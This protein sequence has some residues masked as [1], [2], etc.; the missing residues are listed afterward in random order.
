[1]ARVKSLKLLAEIR[2]T[3]HQG[4]A[5]YEPGCYMVYQVGPKNRSDEFL[6]FLSDSWDA[7]SGEI[8]YLLDLDGV[9]MIG[10]SASSAITQGV[11]Q[12][13]QQRKKPVILTNVDEEAL[14]A[15]RN[16]R[17]MKQSQRTLLALDVKGK[18]QF[19]GEPPDRH[20][21]L[22]ELLAQ[23]KRASASVLAATTQE[24]SKSSV[25]RFSN[26]LQELFSAGLVNREKVSGSER[27][28]AAER[29]WTYVYSSP[30]IEI[31]STSSR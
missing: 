14:E 15:L 18:R 10:I 5:E 24:V 9:N 30:Y 3:Y 8:V 12:F 13:C 22:L 29:G 1:M 25:N 31:E 2:R 7:E 27:E 16:C 21:N 26:Y 6:E 4:V 11:V 23:H 17:Y 20:K 19:V 28:D